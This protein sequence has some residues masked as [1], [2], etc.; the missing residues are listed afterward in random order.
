MVKDQ[1]SKLQRHCRARS[2]RILEALARELDKTHPGA[3]TNPPKV[4]ER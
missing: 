4:A 1:L 2:R 3:A